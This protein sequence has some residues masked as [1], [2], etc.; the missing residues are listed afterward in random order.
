MKAD[1]TFADGSHS[2]LPRLG[3]IALSNGC[4]IGFSTRSP[5]PTSAATRTEG[6]EESYTSL[7]TEHPRTSHH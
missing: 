2:T 7:P 5:S 4:A 1:L 3:S 6:E